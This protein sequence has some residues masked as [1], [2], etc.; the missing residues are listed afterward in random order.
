M[1]SPLPLLDRLLIELQVLVAE[2]DEHDSFGKVVFRQP[3]VR[4]VDDRIDLLFDDVTLK[5][6]DTRQRIPGHGECLR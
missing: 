2:E 5:G 4:G 3:A 1:V 6:V